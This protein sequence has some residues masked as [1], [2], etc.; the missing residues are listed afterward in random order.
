MLVYFM[1]FTHVI[2]AGK[3]KSWDIPS[4]LHRFEANK[5][6]TL[7]SQIEIPAIGKGSEKKSSV[8]FKTGPKIYF[9]HTSG[10]TLPAA[11]YWCAIE[12]AARVHSK[13]PICIFS[14]SY[15][16]LG[17]KMK[18]E[19]NNII[20]VRTKSS[21]VFEDAYKGTALEAWYKR[22]LNKTQKQRGPEQNWLSNKSNAM[23]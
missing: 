16:D 21:D 5:E 14:N 10:E 2:I 19:H 6:S 3:S 17:Q 4:A 7:I 11:L 1:V 22:E 20:I 23:R 15:A 12:S 18:L 8:C 9:A 13:I